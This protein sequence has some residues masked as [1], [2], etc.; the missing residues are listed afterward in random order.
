MPWSCAPKRALSPVPRKRAPPG[1]NQNAAEPGADA[2]GLGTHT[3]NVPREAR[4]LG[5]VGTRR[6]G[7]HNKLSAALAQ[8]TSWGTRGVLSGRR[9]SQASY[10]A[11]GAKGRGVSCRFR[12]QQSY[13]LMLK[14]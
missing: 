13:V 3:R 6:A 12:A 14:P 9:G 2:Q 4:V 8:N 5:R 11:G 1:Q 7:C 10:L